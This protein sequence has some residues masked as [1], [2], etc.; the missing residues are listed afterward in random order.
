MAN[1]MVTFLT[2]PEIQ[3]LIG[4]YGVKEYGLQLFAPCAG[5]EP[6]Q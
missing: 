4:D 1:N 5:N 6:T 3:K 2:S